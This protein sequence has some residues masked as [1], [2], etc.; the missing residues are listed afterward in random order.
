MESQI[1]QPSHLLSP[2]KNFSSKDPNVDLIN[3]IVCDCDC[4]PDDW[5]VP[6]NLLA[7]DHNNYI[8]YVSE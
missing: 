5:S 4:G 2:S 8:N 6:D 7:Y 3:L 1:D